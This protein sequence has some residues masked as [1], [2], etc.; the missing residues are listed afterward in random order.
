MLEVNAGLIKNAA[1]Q[2]FNSRKYSP[3]SAGAR[4]FCQPVMI[5]TAHFGPADEVITKA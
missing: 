4:T 5:Q 1:S 2:V 3:S